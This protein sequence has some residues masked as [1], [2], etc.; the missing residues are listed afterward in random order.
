ME[1][2]K[3]IGG[4]ITKIE[5]NSGIL[6]NSNEQIFKIKCLK[7]GAIISLTCRFFCPARIRDS[8]YAVYNTMLKDDKEFNYMIKQPCV[9]INQDKNSIVITFVNFYKIEFKEAYILYNNLITNSII[10]S[11]DKVYNYITSLAQKW[12]DDN[13][14]QVLNMLGDLK[15][16]D[17]L[18]EYWYKEYNLR[19][20]HL[21]GLNNKEI[22][23][24]NM[25]S[26]QL[27]NQCID[28]PYIVYAINMEKC[29]EILDLLNKK[30]NIEDKK[31]GEIIRYIWNNTENRKWVCTPTKFICNEFP[32]IKLYTQT[33]KDKYNMVIDHQSAYIKN[34]Y[35]IEK[36]IANYFIELVK[37]DPVKYDSPINIKYT[38]TQK[39]QFIRYKMIDNDIL[40]IDQ[41]K[42][43][44]GA[45]DHKVCIITGGPGTG[46]TKVIS[47]IVKNLD[48]RC[49]TYALTSYTGKAVMRIRELT[50]KNAFTMNKMIY[51][52]KKNKDVNVVYDY[53]IIDEI[54]M[55]TVSLLY[56]FLMIYKN[57][58]QLIFVGDIN[59]LE[60]IEHGNLLLQLIQSQ[61]IPTYV[62]T[63]NHRVQQ[64]KGQEDGILL[65]AN[66]IINHDISNGNFT[67]K[68]TPNFSVIVG[69]I[70]SVFEII[71]YCH[72]SG[73]ESKSLTVI[74]PYN[75]NI[76]L[77]NNGYKK[78][79]NNDSKFIIDSRGVKW[80]IND[81][82]MLKKNFSKDNIYNGQQGIIT[83]INTDKIEVFFECS[84]N[85][86]LFYLEPKIKVYKKHN[87]DDNGE[88][89]IDDLTV[90]KL[91]HSYAITVDKSQG[92]EYDFVILYLSEN[93]KASG[94]LNKKRIYTAITRS[95]KI[96][97]IITPSKLLLESSVIRKAP[98]RFENLNKILK[99]NLPQL[100]PFIIYEQI[101]NINHD[102]LDD[103]S[104]YFMQQNYD[105]D[106]D[107]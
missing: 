41:Q 10:E 94:F 37:T 61:T 14:N 77:L 93:A 36:Y 35:N 69:N 17:K 74:T 39:T 30:P 2:S 68:N 26:E 71:K 6:K 97:W 9:L 88:D 29:E 18:L 47:E 80:S 75:D 24:S 55:V 84:K 12:H 40:S 3:E 58:K 27:F 85:T 31:M 46:K 100:K 28:N 49:L 90:L 103:E 66:A 87:D 22:I 79:Y 32:E 21:L 105:D 70:D 81:R 101:K 42:A 62:L 82:V 106:E 72:D 73:I 96:C 64:I 98:W 76:E 34:I 60:P 51:D 43:V 102:D 50:N 57:I 5:Y 25:T 1:Q 52:G 20:L 38:S 7:T 13:D 16:V 53:V 11:E 92:S 83:N 33:L 78:I 23:N 19:M 65:N 99:N 86:T 8:I 67:F 59:Q 44:Q 56:H 107:Y 89:D 15:N 63:K 48:E 104:K 95:R 54:S 91:I 4:I 45:L